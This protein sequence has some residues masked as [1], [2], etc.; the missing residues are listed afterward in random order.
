MHDAG[1]PGLVRGERRGRVLRQVDV[2]GKRGHTGNGRDGQ[3]QGRETAR[4]KI[5]T[6]CL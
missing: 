5:H 6:K 1:V 4:K 2:R 3:G